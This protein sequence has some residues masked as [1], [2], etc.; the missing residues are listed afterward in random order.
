MHVQYHYIPAVLHQWPVEDA[1]PE[2]LS[3]GAIPFV[4][5]FSTRFLPFP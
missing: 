2:R 5:I 3:I 4:V 1:V